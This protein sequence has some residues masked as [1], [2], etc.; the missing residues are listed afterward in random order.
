MGQD[1][2]YDTACAMC[3]MNHHREARPALSASFA[4]G[5]LKVLYGDDDESFEA[6]AGLLGLRLAACRLFDDQVP[7]AYD[8]WREWL[9]A[10]ECTKKV[11][12]DDAAAVNRAYA[13]MVGHCDA[14]TT[15]RLNE[16]VTSISARMKATA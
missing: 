16:L 1:I 4:Q 6:R 5:V 8:G 3:A 13:R 2:V 10:I 9:A 15:S 12:Y 14:A 7:D 11:S